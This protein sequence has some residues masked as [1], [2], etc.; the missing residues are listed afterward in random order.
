MKTM[1]MVVLMMMMT[2]MAMMKMITIMLKPRESSLWTD[3]TPSLIPAGVNLSM[4]IAM[5]MINKSLF[6]CN[7]LISGW[8]RPAW[9]GE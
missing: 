9:Q 4:I 7:D 5:M 3:F 2:M 8:V 6:F 1:M